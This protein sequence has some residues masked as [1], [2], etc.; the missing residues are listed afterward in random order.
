MQLC[1]FGIDYNYYRNVCSM[2]LVIT[3]YLL[4]TNTLYECTCLAMC[5]AEHKVI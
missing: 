2:E 4:S 5:C 3:R 1:A